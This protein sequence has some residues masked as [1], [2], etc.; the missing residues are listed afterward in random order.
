LDCAR[1]T[2]EKAASVAAIVIF[3]NVSV[4]VLC[5]IFMIAEDHYSG[6]TSIVEAGIM[7]LLNG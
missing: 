6:K 5:L 1:V 7:L 2:P 3:E 4:T